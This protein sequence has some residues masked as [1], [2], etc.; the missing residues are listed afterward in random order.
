M[1]ARARNVFV[2]A[3]GLL[4]IWA[5]LSLLVNLPPFASALFG[6]FHLALALEVGVALGL[7]ALVRAARGTTPRALVHLVAFALTLMIF[8]RVADL[9]A[10]TIVDRPLN[11]YLDVALLP[12]VWDVARTLAGPALA[13]SA[14]AGL[15]I[16]LVL[17]HVGLA[18]LFRWLGPRFDDRAHRSALAVLLGLALV[19][20]VGQR[21]L[22]AE[23]SGWRPVG[24]SASLVVAQQAERTRDVFARRAAFRAAIGTDVADTIPDDALLAALDGRDVLV[25]FVESYG[26]TA[27]DE[28]SYAEIVAP[29]LEALG[30]AA[31]QA[32]FSAATGRMVAA[33]VG[34]QSWLNHA[35]LMSGRF[36]DD[37]TLYALYLSE[38]PRTLVHDFA[39]AGYRTVQSKP[40]ITL[41]WPE[42]LQ[43]G[44]DETH[45]VADMGYEGPD[46]YWGIVPDQFALDHLARMEIE[47]SPRPPLFAMIALISSHAPWLP[48]PEVVPWEALG[49]GSVF[50]TWTR[51]APL[52]RDVWR[53]PP[54]VRDF[55]RRSVAH[56]LDAVAVFLRDRVDPSTL[57]IVLGD[58][59]PATLITGPDASRAV[60]VHVF[61]GDPDLLAPFAA[62]GFAPG[63]AL[64]PAPAA[65]DSAIPRMDAFR[66]FLLETFSPRPT[67][68]RD[69]SRAE[70][71]ASRIPATP[72][73]A[74]ARARRE[75]GSQ[76]AA[77]EV[78]GAH[79][80]D[81]EG[82]GARV[83]GIRPADPRGTRSPL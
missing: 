82:A 33:S 40:A 68:S 4:A 53:H 42:G 49:D 37:Q 77:S 15:A 26:V 19:V 45:V 34:G 22:L 35:S 75:A 70:A 52:A 46:F 23:I 12:A 51:D 79:V 76:S 54:L 47:R 3:L 71:D 74:I 11:L 25:V 27:L 28:P 63:V 20:F 8:L 55:Y 81:L 1:S 38:Q 18:R 14:F 59:Q 7:F 5:A 6:L 32:G 80:W 9:V 41:P 57:V 21:T 48:V 39:R 73:G 67:A 66:P 29:S 56:S 83:T 60:P 30:R 61:S 69:R 58:H 17:V 44:F 16:G 65:G 13:V 10:R 2:A 78:T 36:I 24:A 64:P 43:L 62:L 31:A 50:E 72:R